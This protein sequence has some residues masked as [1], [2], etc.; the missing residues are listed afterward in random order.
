LPVES[1]P[2]PGCRESEEDD[3]SLSA[4]L[5]SLIPYLRDTN[6]P[7]QLPTYF[8]NAIF[9][10]STI[11]GETSTTGSRPVETGKDYTWS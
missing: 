6:P 8:G 1:V 3:T 9:D 2:I 4:V 5:D 7:V 11:S 10:P